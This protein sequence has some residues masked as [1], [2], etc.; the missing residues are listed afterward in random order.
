MSQEW[1]FTWDGQKLGPVSGAQLKQLASSGRLK[2]T[3]KVCK[4]GMEKWVTASSVKGLF[5]AGDKPPLLKPV[6]LKRALDEESSKK[7]QDSSFTA[8]SPVLGRFRDFVDSLGR[9]LSPKGSKP[10]ARKSQQKEVVALPAREPLARDPVPASGEA[11]TNSSSVQMP[12][13]RDY[14]RRAMINF[15]CPSCGKDFQVKDKYAGKRSKCLR[16]PAARHADRK[17]E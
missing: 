13:A 6:V 12:G 1:Y 4:K 5:R 11:A 17:S 15:S 14:E 16:H 9:Q 8:N 10:E 3:D 7:P 2:P